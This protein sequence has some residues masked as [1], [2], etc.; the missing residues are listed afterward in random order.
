MLMLSRLLLIASVLSF[1][2]QLNRTIS[3]R[4]SSGISTYYVLFNLVSTTEQFVLA[5]YY[6]VNN[7]DDPGVF[8]HYP[9]N[10]GDWINLAQ[11][12][13]VAILWLT[14]FFVCLYLPS[15]HRD[16]SG[17]FAIGAYIAFLLISV[18]PVFADAIEPMPWE[19]RKWP[20]SLFFGYHS[21]Y[22]SWIIT[23]FNVA[24]VCYQAKEMLSRPWDRALSHVGLATQALVF[25]LIAISWIGRVKFPY[26]EHGFPWGFLSTW[27]ELVGW[28]AVDN[29]IFAL[30]QAILLWIG[31]CRTTSGSG[32][33]HEETE[34]LLRS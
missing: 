30:G 17:K 31:L 1:V 19:D 13:V 11:T 5:F 32:G 14:I 8:V 2:P 10:A 20:M 9:I 15:D 16:G 25:A 29:G 4:K 34:P 7:F 18:V 21:L 3:R 12:T 28:A 33:F 22:L 24:A 23:G 27:Y 26:E 6:I